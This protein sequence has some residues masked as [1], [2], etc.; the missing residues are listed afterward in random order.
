[1]EEHEHTEWINPIVP[2]IKPD[3]SLRL[4]LDPKRPKQGYRKESMVLQN[5]T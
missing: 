4:C 1:M 3:G 5:D 2:V